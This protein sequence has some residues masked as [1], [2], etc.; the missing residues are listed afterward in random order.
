MRRSGTA[1]TE[2][3]EARR[4]RRTDTGDRTTTATTIDRSAATS[5]SLQL[6]FQSV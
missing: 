1:R 2:T 3:Q 6:S 5:L 4:T